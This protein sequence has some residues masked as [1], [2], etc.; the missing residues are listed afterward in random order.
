[1]PKISEEQW[2]ERRLQILEAAWRCFYRNGVQSTTMEDIITESRM[3]ASAM[4]RYFR[5]KE[6]IILSAISASMGAL[7]AQVAP[8]I[9][10]AEV[11]NPADFIAK[12]LLTIERFSA[13]DGY[14]LLPIA[15][16]GWSEAQRDER[17][18][19]LLRDSYLRFRVLF[20]E[21]VVQWQR[22][23]VVG[24]QASALEVAQ[25]LQSMILGYIVQRTIMRDVAAKGQARG[26]GAMMNTRFDAPGIDTRPLE[27]S[28]RA[29][30][31]RRLVTR[32]RKK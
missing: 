12:M 4:Y 18:R 11:S 19:E 16:H 23:G 25:V 13:R 22:N 31:T 26:V 28:V 21:R 32:K 14:N 10:G 3:A 7:A 1:M 30:T 2:Q 29:N 27:R 17:V 9:R 15:I 6:D 24:S 5:G 8:L 20:A